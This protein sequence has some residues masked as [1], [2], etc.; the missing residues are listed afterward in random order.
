[1]TQLTLDMP[2]EAFATLHQT[3]KE[4]TREMRIA[5]AVK[6][7]ELGKISQGRGAEI[8]GLTRAAFIDAL[9]RYQVC[10]FQ[11]TAEEIIEELRDVD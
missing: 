11:Y 3:P 1:M 9:S 5:A 10:P 6:W 7:Y 2:E 4:F 8:A